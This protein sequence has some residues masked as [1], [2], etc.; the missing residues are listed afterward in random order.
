[1]CFAAWHVC[2]QVAEQAAAKKEQAPDPDML[3]QEMLCKYITFAKQ[4]CR[5]QLANADY[6]KIS[7][8]FLLSHNLM[9]VVC[10]QQVQQRRQSTPH[11]LFILDV[12]P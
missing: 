7:Q 3:S 2:M 11:L 9:R 10:P 12:N 5:P 4:N 1:M 6:E 8:V